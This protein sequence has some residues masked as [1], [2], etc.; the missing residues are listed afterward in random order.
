VLT[1]ARILAEKRDEINGR[2]KFVF[3]PAEEIG[4]GAK[5][6]IKDGV[7]ENPRPDYVLGVH[8]GN[9]R[10]PVG[11]IGATPGILLCSATTFRIC[12]Q[13]KAEYG[14][15]PHLARDPIVASAAL[16]TALQ[17]IVS[18]NI[19]PM[20]LGVL[21][22]LSINSIAKSQDITQIPS[23]VVITGMIRALEHEV[24]DTILERIEEI[25]DGVCRGLGCTAKF[26]I[27]EMV[28]AVVNDAQLTQLVIDVA[29]SIFPDPVIDQSTQFVGAND[30]A[31]FMQEIPG[32]Y[33]IIDGRNT[34]K[35]QD[36]PL[37]DP[38][39]DFDEEAMVY[40]VALLAAAGLK[41]LKN[42]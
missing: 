11:W 10:D 25:A 27:E 24:R 15:T 3:Q 13:G 9:E 38:R 7:L 33:I 19:D 30:I 31:L 4:R 2:V 5:M 37:H 16:I 39:F 26:E 8:I 32:C 21:T 18:R 17:S 6:M 36:L 41:L 40:G 28:P 12:I 35:G 23:E 29:K 1:V 42:D 14:A 20:K 34:E 22:V